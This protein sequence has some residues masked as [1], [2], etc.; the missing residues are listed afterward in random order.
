MEL[1]DFR[2]EFLYNYTQPG[3]PIAFSGINQGTN[4]VK[5]YFS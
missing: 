1:K 2:N 3:H 5:F 4:A